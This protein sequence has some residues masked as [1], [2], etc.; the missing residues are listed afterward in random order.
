LVVESHTIEL[1]NGKIVSNWPWI[2][3]T[4]FINVLAIS[5]DDKFICL[6]QT[7][8]CIEEEVVAPVGGYIEPNETPLKA[9]QR[10]LL[11]ETGY[12]AM[13]WIKLGDYRVDPNWGIST[14]YLF[15]ARYAHKIQEPV[16]DDFEDQR[17][18]YLTQSELESAL[19]AG[20]LKVFAW[21]TLVA[22]SL[23]YLNRTSR[24]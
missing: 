18:I 10:E 21:A 24:T 5:E 9:A 3:A 11:E 6:R 13:E 15:L 8:Y 12:E 19:V 14:G 20:K 17:L 2:D 7:K 22:M 16:D 4:K 23:M 1:P